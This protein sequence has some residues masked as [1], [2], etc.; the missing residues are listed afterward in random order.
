MDQSS[1]YCID[2]VRMMVPLGGSGGQWT[3]GVSCVYQ[4]WEVVEFVLNTV[5]ATS[6]PKSSQQFL[7]G[8]VWQ[9]KGGWFS[10]R[11]GGVAR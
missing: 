5:F 9:G 4:L 11:E 7:L 10:R 2:T 3:G 8:K 1:G 6:R